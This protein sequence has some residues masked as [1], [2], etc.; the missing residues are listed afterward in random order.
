M[1]IKNYCNFSFYTFN[2]VNNF[3]ALFNLNYHFSI[4][5]NNLIKY[6]DMGC[7]N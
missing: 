5:K 6:T 1:Q 4:H 2:V 3:N 7:S